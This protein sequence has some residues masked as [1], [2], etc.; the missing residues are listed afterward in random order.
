MR[1]RQLLLYEDFIQQLEGVSP[2][3]KEKFVE[4][5]DEQVSSIPLEASEIFISGFRLGVR[6]MAEVFSGDIAGAQ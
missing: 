4:I 1:R 2:A 6:I 3:L 5:M